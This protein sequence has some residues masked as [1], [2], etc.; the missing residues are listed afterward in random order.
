MTCKMH[1]QNFTCQRLCNA[2]TA[3][4]PRG[5]LPVMQPSCTAPPEAIGTAAG[6]DKAS[7]K[8][9]WRSWN[10]TLVQGFLSSVSCLRSIAA[11]LLWSSLAETVESAD[12][13]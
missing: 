8:V 12:C 13:I 4:I 7:E 11:R 3:I 9:D 5:S 6:D 2:A 10:L 1:T